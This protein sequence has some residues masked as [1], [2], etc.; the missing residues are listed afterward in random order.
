MMTAYGA[1]LRLAELVR[2]RPHHI[3]SDR[4]LIHV[5]QGKG[6]KDRYTLLSEWARPFCL[7]RS[8]GWRSKRRPLRHD[9]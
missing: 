3:K 8:R 7:S 6:R 1:G 5:E 4:M 2:L 9:R